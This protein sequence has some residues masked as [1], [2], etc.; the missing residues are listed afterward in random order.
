MDAARSSSGSGVLGAR[1][2]ALGGRHQ[3]RALEQLRQVA[4]HLVP[5]QRQV[6]GGVASARAR[7]VDHVQQHARALDVAQELEPQAGAL[8]RR[9]R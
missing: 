7:G 9:P 4:A 2:V 5:D 8:V 6:G 1:K 3:L